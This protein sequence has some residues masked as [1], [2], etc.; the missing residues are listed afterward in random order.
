MVVEEVLGSG[1]EGRHKGGFLF[2]NIFKS[3]NGILSLVS[4]GI[5]SL[6]LKEGSNLT[7][8]SRL[9]VRTLA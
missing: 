1:Q 3:K 6:T 4:W 2:N 5:T 9:L 8:S 7:F